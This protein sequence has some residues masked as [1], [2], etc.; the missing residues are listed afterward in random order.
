MPTPYFSAIARTRLDISRF[1]SNG[2]SEAS[3]M[4]EVQPALAQASIIARSLQWSRW[5]TTGTGD[6]SATVRTQLTISL[7]LQYWMVLVEGLADDRR[8]ELL[9]GRDHRLGGAV[10]DQVERGDGIAPVHRIAQER[11]HVHERHGG[12]ML[13][14]RLG[15]H[16]A[17][18]AT[19]Q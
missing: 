7:W 2:N 16:R 3:I 13:L 4:I 12:G 18:M 19:I 10:V 8:V 15:A 11:L 1:C 14:E 9:G 6:S 17:R 5:S